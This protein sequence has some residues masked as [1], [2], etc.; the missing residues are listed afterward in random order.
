MVKKA[1]AKRR[2]VTIRKP[3]NVKVKENPFTGLEVSVW[4]AD[5]ALVPRYQPVIKEIAKVV[6]EMTGTVCHE[7]VQV[8]LRW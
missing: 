6:R 8:K 2:K 5:P 4:I 7:C 3:T 1:P